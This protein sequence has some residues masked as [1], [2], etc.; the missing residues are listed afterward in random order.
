MVREG[1]CADRSGCFDFGAGRPS[2]QHDR[3]LCIVNRESCIANCPVTPSLPR[4]PDGR[5]S[6]NPCESQWWM[7]CKV[8]TFRL[9][10]VDA[11]LKVTDFLSCIIIEIPFLVSEKSLIFAL[12]TIPC[13]TFTMWFRWWNHT[14][15]V[16][17]EPLGFSGPRAVH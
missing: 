6:G 7:F 14:K 4:G 17:A 11:S 15:Q 9:R 10:V 13:I 1:E 12:Q 16:C 2:A 8:G 3:Q 5:V